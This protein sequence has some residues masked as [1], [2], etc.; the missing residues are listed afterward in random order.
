MSLERQGEGQAL[1]FGNLVFGQLVR[2]L[3]DWSLANSRGATQQSRLFFVFQSTMVCFARPTFVCGQIT[4]ESYNQTLQSYLG[5][6]RHG[7]NYDLEM[8]VKNC[9]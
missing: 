1:V 8:M 5:I 2:P 3:A 4:P 6:L 9:F 7:E